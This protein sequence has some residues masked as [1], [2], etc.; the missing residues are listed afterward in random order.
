MRNENEKLYMQYQLN[1]IS[2]ALSKTTVFHQRAVHKSNHINK[3]KKPNK[4]T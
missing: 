4:N 2:S 1:Y 3:A